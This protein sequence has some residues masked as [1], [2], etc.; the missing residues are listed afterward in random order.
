MDLALA[1]RIS[2]AVPVAVLF[3]V[4]TVRA[5]RVD[6]KA[7]RVML[8]GYAETITDAQTV[9][10]RRP[11]PALV[12]SL[13]GYPIAVELVPDTLALRTV[14]RLWV[15][16]R[17][18]RRHDGRLSVLV[19]SADEYAVEGSFT[20]ILAATPAWRAPVDVLG[21]VRAPEL[22]RRLESIDPT[23]VTALRRLLITESEL[24][25]SLVARTAHP[26]A[27]GLLRVAR[28]GTG[29]LPRGLVEQS[30][31]LLRAIETALGQPA[32]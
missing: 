23:T 18:R 12:G 31:D 29:V 4:M 3:G 24:E 30:I 7:R 21:G 5:W 13:D 17:W 2:I 16:I 11:Y 28:F 19:R 8:S 27:Y 10:K 14:P 9:W 32:T 15:R 6:R 25:L 20:R 22:M 1:V 26:R